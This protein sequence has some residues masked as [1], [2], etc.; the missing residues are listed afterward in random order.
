MSDDRVERRD[1]YFAPPFR[2]E[3]AKIVGTDDARVAISLDALLEENVIPWSVDNSHAESICRDAASILVS[4]SVPDPAVSS[5][6]LESKRLLLMEFQVEYGEEA[7]GDRKGRMEEASRPEKALFGTQLVAALG[8]AWRD[9]PTK[10]DPP[11][12]LTVGRTAYNPDTYGLIHYHPP[13]RQT[14]FIYSAT[15][16]FTNL[17]PGVV[18]FQNI[19]ID[20]ATKTFVSP[21]AIGRLGG[22][23]HDRRSAFRA[24]NDGKLLGA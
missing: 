21:S 1:L 22:L 6:V 20:F 2:T 18:S 23:M 11:L 13:E 12:S 5:I 17:H 7:S 24:L 10:D 3:L 16:L 15:E 14:T 9:R 8:M 19:T 4:L